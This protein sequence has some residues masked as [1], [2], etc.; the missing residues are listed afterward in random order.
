MN[1]VILVV[2]FLVAFRVIRPLLRLAISMLAKVISFGFFIAMALLLL[3]AVLSH[4]A[5]I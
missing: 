5:V 1:L 4:G 2:V 3:L